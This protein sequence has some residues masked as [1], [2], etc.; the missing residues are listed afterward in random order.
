MFFPLVALLG[1]ASGMAVDD[2]AQS[3]LPQQLLDGS[4]WQFVQTCMVLSL[5]N[6]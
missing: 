3:I 6:N 2:A 4:P 1:Q 5:Y